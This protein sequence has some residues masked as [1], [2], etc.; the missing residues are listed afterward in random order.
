MKKITFLI[1]TGL[2][3]CTGAFAQSK[4]IKN[5]KKDLKSSIK[6]KKEDK[7]E[8]RKDLAHLRLKSAVKENKE[9]GRHRRSIHKKGEHLEAHGVK[10]PVTTAKHQIKEEKEIKKDSK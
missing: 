9:V 1:I 6:D 10:H 4:D 7:Q 8:T 5:D 2:V 3:L